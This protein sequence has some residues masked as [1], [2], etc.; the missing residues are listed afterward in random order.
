MSTVRLTVHFGN[1]NWFRIKLGENTSYG[2]LI[3]VCT[4]IINVEAS[5]VLYVICNGHILG[6]GDYSY[7]KSLSGIEAIEARLGVTVHV[8]LRN[9]DRRLSDIY[10]NIQCIKYQKWLNQVTTR[11]Q[12]PS[13]TRIRRN[14]VAGPPGISNLFSGSTNDSLTALTSI[15]QDAMQNPNTTVTGSVP[16]TGNLAGSLTGDGPINYDQAVN[17]SNVPVVLT[18]QQFYDVTTIKRYEDLT[19]EQRENSCFCGTGLDEP[20]DG[21]S[22]LVILDGCNH[23]Y[24]QAC[25]KHHL[26]TINIKCPICNRDTRESL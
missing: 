11:S 9:T 1:S 13:Q 4:S 21:N 6:Q 23:L 20:V 8:V 22:N 19:P 3:D 7:D 12:Q 24:H 18:E 15:I 26:T 2:E 16:L 25:L 14:A 17:L 10:D 5:D